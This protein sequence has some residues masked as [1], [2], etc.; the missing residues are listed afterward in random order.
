MAPRQ[1]RLAA[2]LN[3]DA[4]GYTR[5]MADDEIATVE[6]VTDYQRVMR[7]LIESLGGRTVDTPTR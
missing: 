3:A 2:L 5:L 6:T 1:R 7:Q 4:V